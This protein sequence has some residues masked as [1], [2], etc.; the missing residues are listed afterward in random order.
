MSTNQNEQQRRDVARGAAHCDQR[1]RDIEGRLRTDSNPLNDHALGQSG[2]TLAHGMRT[3]ETMGELPG[4]DDDGHASWAAYCRL[5]PRY[6]EMPKRR[7]PPVTLDVGQVVN[8]GLRLLEGVEKLREVIR[9]ECP[10][11]PADLIDQVREAAWALS[12]AEMLRRGA[13]GGVVDPTSTLVD[14]LRETRARLLGDAKPLVPRGRVSP[15]AVILSQGNSPRNVAL[16]VM[17]LVEVLG[18]NLEYLEGR[19]LTTR[20][21]LE[22]AACAAQRLLQR[23]GAKEQSIEGFEAATLTRQRAVAL[24]LELYEELRWAVRFVRRK[25]KDADALMPSMYTLRSKNDTTDGGA[26]YEA[27]GGRSRPFRQSPAPS[28][29]R[30]SLA[31]SRAGVTTSTAPQLSSNRC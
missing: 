2:A 6:D 4:C 24:F 29:P 12:H 20:S 15:R 25:H 8:R 16:D 7:L 19:S 3:P 13:A 21:D 26:S 17:R 14:A 18:C 9:R 22:A 31:M 30:K 1:L 10:T 11:L 27:L 23:L 5:K 28:A